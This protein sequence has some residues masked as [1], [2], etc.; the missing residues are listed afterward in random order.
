MLRQCQRDVELARIAA[1]SDNLKGAVTNSYDAI[2]AAVECHMNAAR[3]RIANRPGAHMVAID[4][5]AEHMA[6]IFVPDRLV[7]YESLRTIRHA[8]EYAFSSSTRTR[9][10]KKDADAAVALAHHVVRA[11]IR[12]WAGQAKSPTRTAT[13]RKQE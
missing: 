13:R 4:Y 6:D 8:A 9:L 3:L 7:A 12:S 5:A 1:E 2:R 10:T 11:V